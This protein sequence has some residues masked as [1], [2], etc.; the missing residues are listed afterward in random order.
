MGP[1]ESYP[2][3]WPTGS[4]KDSARAERKATSRAALGPT[5]ANSPKTTG[6]AGESTKFITTK[7]LS[8]TKEPTTLKTRTVPKSTL[9]SQCLDEKPSTKQTSN[10]YL[11]NQGIPWQST[12]FTPGLG[13]IVV[14]ELR[15]QKSS[16]TAKNIYIF[17]ESKDMLMSKCQNSSVIKE[18]LRNN[19][20]KKIRDFPGGPVAKT[21]HSQYRG[22]GFDLWSGNYIR[23]AATKTQCSQINK[24]YSFYKSIE[25]VIKMAVYLSNS[26][27]AQC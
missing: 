17:I 21:L 20:I 25:T 13:S 10:E 26:S 19:S 24:I 8:L 12:T 6:E 1:T 15:A 4:T 11:W 16:S 23:N 7:R 27:H 18:L 3:C 9:S 5:G 22:P 14:R 2:L